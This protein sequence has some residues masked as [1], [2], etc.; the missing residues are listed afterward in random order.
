MVKE[1]FR[2]SQP[3][4]FAPSSAQTVVT[5]DTSLRA[6]EDKGRLFVVEGDV[7]IRELVNAL[8]AVGVSTREMISI[9]QTIK[10]AGALHAELEII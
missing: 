10:A 5:P 8:N 1:D 7:T 9:L 2:V 3:M 6:E 4:P